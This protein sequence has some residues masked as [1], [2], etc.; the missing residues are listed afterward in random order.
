MIIVVS[1]RIL[2]FFLPLLM[3]SV[4]VAHSD[5]TFPSLLSVDRLTTDDGLPSNEVR[6]IYKDQTGYIWFLTSRGLVKYNAHD[7]LIYQRKANNLNSLSN[8]ELFD[9]A[10][11]ENG[12]F[13]IASKDGLNYLDTKTESFRRYFHDP[14][15]QSSLSDNSINSLLKDSKG[16]YWIGTNLGG[17]NFYDSKN[18]R[19]ISYRHDP[20]NPKSLASDRIRVL[21]QDPSGNI[22]AGLLGGCTLDRFDP[23]TGTAEHFGIVNPNE[24]YP[25]VICLY[26]DSSGIVWYGSWGYGLYRFDPVKGEYRNYRFNANDPNSISSNI[27]QCITKDENGHLWIGTRNG[28]LCIFDPDTEQFHRIKLIRKNDPNATIDTVLDIYRD[29]QGILWFGTISDGVCRY[30]TNQEQIRYFKN[31]PKDSNTINEDR[32][33]ALCTD[34]DG[35]IWIGTNG[36]GLNHYDPQTGVFTNYLSDKNNS[37]GLDVKT[38][39]SLLKDHKGNLWVGSWGS[40]NAPFCRYNIETKEFHCYPNRTNEPDKFHGAVARTLCEDYTGHIWIGAESYGVISFDP[41]SEIFHSYEAGTHGLLFTTFQKI[42]EDSRRRLWIATEGGLEYYDRPNDRFAVFLPDSNNSITLPN[43][44]FNT[45]FEDSLS[46]LWVGTGQGLFEISPDYKVVRQFSLEDG[47]A[48]NAVKS[49]IEDASGFLWIG[50]DNGKI[51]RLDLRTASVINFDKSDGLQN[52]SFNKNCCTKGKWGEL[53]FG[54]LNG[55]NCIF[56][57]RISQNAW[58]PP[59]VIASF[60]VMGTP[61]PFEQHLADQKRL[62]LNYFQN[63]FSCEFAALNYTRSHKNQYKYRLLPLENNWNSSGTHRY[64]RYTSLHPGDYSLQVIGSN[65]DSVWNNEG[66]TIPIHIESPFWKT[67]WFQTGCAG[68]LIL[69]VISRYMNL[70]NH[71]KRL[72]EEVRKQTR[73]LSEANAVLEKLSMQDG[74][75]QLSNRRCFDTHIQNEWARGMR[76]QTSLSLLFFDVDHFKMYND[77]YGHIAGDE[78]LKKIAGILQQSISRPGDLAAR[79]GGEEFVIILTDA[80]PPNAVKF[81]EGLRK[82][83]EELKIPHESSPIASVVTLSIGV[84]SV[85]PSKDFSVNSLIRAADEG[86]YLSKT[87]G[88]NCVNLVVPREEF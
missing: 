2:K 3:I 84:A 78:C 50:L 15:T 28:G 41:E 83:V 61:Y 76:S 4:M 82:Q 39:I 11:G 32:I 48:D 72:E 58:I 43:N 22:W 5:S 47:L 88:R 79:Y 68:L 51:S 17:L 36:G 59:I 64:A 53:Y 38:V 71:K 56:P 29:P 66:V 52:L 33:Y 45:I 75:T 21:S 34:S 70:R 42:F 87:N 18:N 8:D 7:F 57:D 16:N 31:N 49:I 46:N 20:N 12:L 74:L 26:V 67:W 69:F 35:S 23:K 27:V 9:I 62:V 65:N 55:L 73:K 37:P 6:K 86:L 13:W 63:T 14:D 24:G 54:G 44:N 1:I 77:L 10:G 80:N 60:D 30:D 40:D 19:F 81:A 25:N 85:V